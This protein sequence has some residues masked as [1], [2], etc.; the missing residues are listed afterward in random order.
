VITNF[1]YR[2]PMTHTMPFWLRRFF[3]HILPGLLWLDSP[4]LRENELRLSNNIEQS[5]VLENP[6]HTLDETIQDKQRIKLKYID[7]VSY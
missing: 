6:F 1:Y 7:R 3:L 5:I 4:K 2:T